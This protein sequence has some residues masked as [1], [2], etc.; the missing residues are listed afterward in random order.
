MGLLFD[1]V[2][3][4]YY[5]IQKAILYLISILM[6]LL[7]VPVVC[8]PILI[9]CYI[10]DI[11]QKKYIATIPHI[12]A[13]LVIAFMIFL[14]IY[15]FFAWYVAQEE[16]NITRNSQSENYPK[17]LSFLSQIENYPNILLFLIERK[18]ALHKGRK[19]LV[20]Y[21]DVRR[22]L[23]LVNHNLIITLSSDSTTIICQEKHNQDFKIKTILKPLY[24][25]PSKT[26]GSEWAYTD[27]WNALCKKI[28][29]Y[30]TFSDIAHIFTAN[31][32]IN[33]FT[34]FNNCLNE[35]KN[36]IKDSKDAFEE[37]LSKFPKLALKEN[38]PKE[39]SV[40]ISQS[41]VK[42]PSDIE[43]NDFGTNSERKVDL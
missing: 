12:D 35:D 27:V 26:T 9:F 2:E 20:P 15:A 4:I 14:P 23:K 41:E 43:E 1:S 17:F 37:Y 11:I 28:N 34:D 42:V 38:A 13:L 33:S 16:E 30:T 40:E 24:K 8:S 5:I 6:I 36:Y 10:A 25:L 21:K 32:Y 18:H 29:P 39:N 3:Y 31:N 22:N 19:Y 7:I